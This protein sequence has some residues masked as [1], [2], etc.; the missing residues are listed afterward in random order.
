M[1][2]IT[3]SDAQKLTRDL[4]FYLEQERRHDVH[5]ELYELGEKVGARLLARWLRAARAG[6]PPAMA[7]HQDV[8]ELTG[9]LLLWSIDVAR[10]AEDLLSD[11]RLAALAE[12]W[13]A[14]VGQ[15]HHVRAS[16][17]AYTFRQ[18]ERE[19]WTDYHDTFP[20]AVDTFLR[21]VEQEGAAVVELVVE[22]SGNAPDWYNNDDPELLHSEVALSHGRINTLAFHPDYWTCDCKWRPIKPRTEA[23]CRLCQAEAADRPDPKSADVARLLRGQPLEP[24]L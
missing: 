12:E 11:R 3:D 21:M 9:Q 1:Q 14:R 7:V 13:K 16:Y 23:C 2:T 4:K 15:D 8:A 10:Q 17:R 6:I 18:V 20:A 5:D 19:E 24:A 22:D